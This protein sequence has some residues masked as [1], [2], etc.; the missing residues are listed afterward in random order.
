MRLPACL[1]L[2][3]PAWSTCLAVT[4][5]C[6]SRNLT[7]NAV[8]PIEYGYNGSAFSKSTG[9]AQFSTSSSFTADLLAALRAAASSRLEAAFGSR[10]TTPTAASAPS[11]PSGSVSPAHTRGH[12]RGDGCWRC[13]AETLLGAAAT[14]EVSSGRSGRIPTAHR[15]HPKGPLRSREIALNILS[16]RRYTSVTP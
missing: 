12:F 2:N 4:P 6:L 15:W 9:R 3:S 8:P 16:R 5:K 11:Q 13:A 14:F 7:R 1:R 10:C